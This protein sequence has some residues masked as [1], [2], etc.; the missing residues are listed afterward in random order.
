MQ[1][2][3]DLIHDTQWDTLVILD[4]CRFDIFEKRVP[5]YLEGDLIKVKSE[6]SST[7][8]WLKKTWPCEYNIDY[9]SANPGITSKGAIKSWCDYDASKHF[10]NVIDVWDW[11]WCDKLGTVHPEEVTLGAMFEGRKIVHYLQPHFPFIGRHKVLRNG[12]L[13]KRRGGGYAAVK[14]LLDEGHKEYVRLAYQDN[15]DLV[16]EYVK[17]LWHYCQ[18]NGDNVVVTADHGE[19]LDRPERHP[20][21]CNDPVLREVPWYIIRF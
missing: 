14:N 21:G 8:E 11:G 6:G 1:S 13:S 10:R 2:Q 20:G 18:A 17:E 5:N 19:Y 16:L 12:D 15:V 9:I 3:Y 7:P 4:A